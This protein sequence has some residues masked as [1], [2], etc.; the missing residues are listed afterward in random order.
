M[1]ILKAVISIAVIRLIFG[2]GEGAMEFPCLLYFNGLFVIL[3]HNFP[4]YMGFK[5]GKGTASLVGMLLGLDLWLGLIGIAVLVIATL[6][7]DFIAMGTMALLGV[8]LIHT[9]LFHPDP[10]IMLSVIVIVIM[11]V[12]KHWPNI[13]KIKNGEEKSV[14]KTL[15]KK[16]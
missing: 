8:L 13:I 4:F 12:Y 10:I 9:L 6:I 14:R 5:G 16:D 2:G 15:M 11:S 3:G 1:D 7:T